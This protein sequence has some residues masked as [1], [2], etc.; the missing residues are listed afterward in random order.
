MV[1]LTVLYNLP[2]GADEGRFLAWRLGDGQAANAASPGV[3]RTDF[4]RAVTTP[5][6]E[7]RYRFVTEAVF[8]TMA[9]LEAAFFTPEAQAQLRDDLARIDEPVFLI[10]EELASHEAPAAEARPGQGG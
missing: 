8:A 3:I 4:Y 2:P 9:D 7:P 6:G 5:L 10:S 1:K